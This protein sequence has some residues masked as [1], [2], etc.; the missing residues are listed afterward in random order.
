MEANLTGKVAFVA[1]SSAGIG[2]AI[3][4]KLATNGADIV[5]NGRNPA[6]AIKVRKQIEEL[7]QKVVFEKS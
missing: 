5:L 4:L 6:S 7:G 1:G 2:K 3:A